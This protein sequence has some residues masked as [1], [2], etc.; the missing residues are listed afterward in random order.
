MHYQFLGNYVL[1]TSFSFLFL[2][3][4]KKF[5]HSQQAK[6]LFVSLTLG[7]ILFLFFNA[8][9][10]GRFLIDLDRGYPEIYG[11][12]KELTSVG[13]LLWLGLKTKLRLWFAFSLFIFYV[14]LD[15]AF[16]F[17][18][19]MGLLIRQ[20]INVSFFSKL[21]RVRQRDIGEA[22]YYAVIGFIFLFPGIFFYFHEKKDSFQRL[23]AN[24]LVVAFG[25]LCFFC[26]ALDVIDQGPTLPVLRHFLNLLEDYGE[27]LALSLLLAFCIDVFRDWN[28]S[29]KSPPPTRPSKLA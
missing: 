13:I 11:Y 20:W 19:Q 18:E 5:L 29:M 23:A 6:I 10:K 21:L 8:V 27:M 9:L 15:D 25:V 1:L 28:A 26:V 7:D 22:M 4:G 2:F 12:I 24:K 17:H 16:M 3:T 14:F